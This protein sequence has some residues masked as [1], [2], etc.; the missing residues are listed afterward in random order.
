MPTAKDNRL[1]RRNFLKATGV[2]IALP[3]FESL[4]S[5]SAADGKQGALRRMVCVGNEFG[6]YPEAFF[7]AKDGRDYE[8]TTLLKPLESHREHMTLFSHLD[9]G[10]KGGH[11]AIHGFLTGVKAAEA[12]SGLRGSFDS[13]CHWVFPSSAA[14]PP[15]ARAAF[16][17]ARHMSSRRAP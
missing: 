14:A 3:A 4:S 1:Q 10:L 7:P 8:S 16:S 9:H 13:C 12:K 11:F 5:A 17:L 6:M 2:V 15:W